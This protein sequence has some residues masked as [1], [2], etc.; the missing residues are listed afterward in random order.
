MLGS[1]RWHRVVLSLCVSAVV[2]YVACGG[3]EGPT[4]PPCVSASDCPAEHR[5]INNVCVPPGVDGGP[6]PMDSGTR[7]ASSPV[8]AN[9][10]VDAFVPT[11]APMSGV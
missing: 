8:D 11:D 9:T 7:D 6:T 10:P 3:N 5:C 4:L 2:F 1:R